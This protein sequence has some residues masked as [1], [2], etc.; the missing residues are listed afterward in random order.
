MKC[1]QCQ[2]DNLGGAKFYDMEGLLKKM[3]IEHPTS[4]IEWEKMKKQKN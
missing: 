1:P 3:N 4:D 2:F